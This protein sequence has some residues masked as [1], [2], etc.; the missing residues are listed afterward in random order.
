M[1]T[2]TTAE[3]LIGSLSSILRKNFQK[4]TLSLTHLL[5]SKENLEMVLKSLYG[6]PV[7]I[8]SD[9]LAD[10]Y[11]LSVM[12]DMEKLTSECVEFF[13]KNIKPETLVADYKKAIKE[14]SLLEKLYSLAIL[15]HIHSLTKEQILDLTSGM[16]YDDIKQFITNN[17][18]VDN[19]TMLCVIEYYCLNKTVKPELFALA[20]FSSLSFETLTT[21]IKN[22][23][24]ISKD[25]YIAVLE[26]YIRNK[27]TSS[28][29]FA[30]GKRNG[31]YEGYRLVKEIEV[32]DRFKK[33]FISECKK[34]LGLLSLDSLHLM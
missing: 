5:V 19:E 29:I 24:Y 27:E 23:P 25:I 7:T 11:T 18:I 13:K 31:S 3:E 12:F 21:R 32:N 20:D 2:P 14:H 17:Y 15:S 26:N 10:L 33:L 28:D 30:I 4:K 22:S 16:S 9:N 34:G 6:Y 1:T 8:T